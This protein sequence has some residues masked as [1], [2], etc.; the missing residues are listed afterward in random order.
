M[1]SRSDLP[2]RSSSTTPLN[3]CQIPLGVRGSEAAGQERFP[4]GY[5][6]GGVDN[7]SRA[8]KSI[9]SDM[10]SSSVGNLVYRMQCAVHE[11]VGHVERYP[12]QGSAS[13]E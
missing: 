10:L 3:F 7:I 5:S 9:P 2:V 12:S 8:V 11:K 13:I 6:I 1:W 4:G